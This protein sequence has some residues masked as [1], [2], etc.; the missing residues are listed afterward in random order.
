[1][2]A[3][4]LIHIVG[5]VW[6][7]QVT[8]SA[9]H[10]FLSPSDQQQITEKVEKLRR[11]LDL[12]SSVAV[13]ADLEHQA[14]PHVEVRVVAEHVG[15]LV[16]SATGPSVITALDLTIPKIEQQVRRAKEKL[17]GH[18]PGRNKHLDSAADGAED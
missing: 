5:K 3:A 17:T 1:M 8:V 15:E 6:S 2:L 10:G 13:T 18:R 4:G 12:I 7:M 11:L 16:A 9:R 14:A